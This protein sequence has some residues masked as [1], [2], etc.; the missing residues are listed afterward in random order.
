MQSQMANKKEKK[1]FNEI[2][3]SPKPTLVDF[4]ATWCG[5][6]RMMIPILKEL[7]AE[8][9]NRANIIK[10]DIDKNPKLTKKLNIQGVPTI[11]IYKNGKVVW[12]RSGVQRAHQLMIALEEFIDKEDENL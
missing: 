9:G 2:I 3:N 8:L 1:S 6:C 4:Y 10:V 7:S 11:A 12:R 5:P